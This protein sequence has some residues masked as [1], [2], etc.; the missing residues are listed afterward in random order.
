MNGRVTLLGAGPGDPELLTLIGKRRLHEADV[1]LYDRLIDPSLLAF[2]SD[3]AS[4]VD[5]GK[6]PEHHKV[7]QSQIN[8]L[9]VDYARD[10]KN[11]V[12]LKAGDPYVFG[13]GGEEDRKS[14][15]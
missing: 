10:G 7:K 15:V 9:L 12:R 14:V 8:Q 13:R 1:V 6:L 3:K 11:V 2:T 5:V 4:L